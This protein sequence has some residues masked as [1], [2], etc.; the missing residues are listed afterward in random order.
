MKFETKREQLYGAHLRG[1]QYHY[2][3]YL[4][5]EQIATAETREYAET[6]A[7]SILLGAYRC[8]NGSVYAS[9]TAD[10]HVV[11]TR[12]FA[13]GAVEFAHHRS[14]DGGQGGSMISTLELTDERTY[15]KRSVS[16]AEFHAHYLTSYN[17][18]VAAA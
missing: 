5:G 15:D 13:P 17:S 7:V 6:K 4:A 1:K 10:G 14:A 16:V 9:V 8:Q 3:V 12:E 18:T 11:T 2:V